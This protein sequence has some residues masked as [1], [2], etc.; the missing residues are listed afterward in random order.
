MKILIADDC[1]IF[2]GLVRG[3]LE[4]RGFDSVCV[5]DGVEALTALAADPYDL[6]LLDLEMPVLDGLGFLQRL[7]RGATQPN[8]PVILMTGSTS[9]H[10]VRQAIEIGVQGCVLKTRAELEDMIAQ[11]DRVMTRQANRAAQGLTK[12]TS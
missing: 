10:A 6:V 12:L 1:K 11:I 5:N 9:T 7:R 8:I 3:E 2:R 4:R